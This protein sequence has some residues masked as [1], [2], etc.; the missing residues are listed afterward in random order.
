[1]RI[2]SLLLLCV[3]FFPFCVKGQTL[4]VSGV[5]YPD[6]ARIVFNAASAP[7]FQAS[8][9]G[10]NVQV[11]F[12][13]PVEAN[14]HEMLKTLHGEVAS[15]SLEDGGK[16]VSIKLKNAD[17]RLRKFRGQSFFGIDLVP[18]K[19]EQKKPS[20]A[21]PIKDIKK[22][23]AQIEKASKEE[24]QKKALAAKEKEKAKAAK[25]AVATDDDPDLIKSEPTKPSKK[26][27]KKN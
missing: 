27:K 4:Q 21:P 6:F 3:I 24:Q 13:S 18:Q 26:K 23:A 16:R 10:G 12:D 14:F 1:V 17:V 7:A 11:V 9:S 20:E 2:K 8:L 19:K 5:A 22:E 25:N 15:A